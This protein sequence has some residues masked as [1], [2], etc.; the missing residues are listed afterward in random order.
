LFH[1]NVKLHLYSPVLQPRITLF[2]LGKIMKIKLIA[3]ACLALCS[4]SAF[5]TTAPVACVSVSNAAVAASG[6]GKT[7]VASVVA[8][9]AAE[10]FVNTC[11]TASSVFYIAGSSALSGAI[12]SVA[13]LDLLDQG[14]ASPRISIIDNGS[15]N[16][17]TGAN[18][19]YAWAGYAPST[20][21]PILVIYNKQNGSAAGISQLLN[22]VPKNSA[23]AVGT[24]TVPEFDVVTA[25]VG[26]VTKGL[27]GNC[28]DQ[29]VVPTTA[30][31]LSATVSCTTHAPTAVTVGIADVRPIELFEL[32]GKPASVTTLSVTPVAIQGFGIAV[33]AKLYAALQTAEGTT[34]QPSIDRS[35]YASLASHNGAIKSSA[36]LLNAVLNT[37]AGGTL[38]DTTPQ[39]RLA[40]RDNY[41]GSQAASNIFFLANACDYTYT[42]GALIK[43]T[44][45]GG[46]VPTDTTDNVA[47][48]LAV[49]LNATSS[50]VNTDLANT[51][52]YTIG[53]VTLNTPDVGAAGTGSIKS[54]AHFVKLNGVSP[55]YE[56]DGT[57]VADH[58]R[59][60]FIN[61]D[62]PFAVES[63]VSTLIKPQKTTYF[64]GLV[65]TLISGLSDSTKHNLEGLG[66]IDGSAGV[67]SQQSH[68]APLGGNNCAPLTNL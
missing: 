5:A 41:S 23:A 21:T 38:P 61:G 20:T 16:G 35:V 65:T 2:L 18:A 63:T 68:V 54:G 28:V 11:L 48:V 56:A 10:N 55:T 32:E 50:N 14:T 53:V 9:T 19:V 60:R 45:G 66:Y 64:P 52:D 62:Y 67:A 12:N 3:G 46:L 26:S 13:P 31:S 25:G 58:Q 44:L 7:A 4:V 24:S 37:A 33:N 34:G 39:L 59:T 29:L 6:T 15:P 47:G 27:A 51:T 40:R 30:G 43:G 49:D 22:A 1:F 36:A 17:S 57:T 42:K 8:H